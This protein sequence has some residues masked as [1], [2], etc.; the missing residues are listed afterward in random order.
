M[1]VLA[2]VA[3]TAIVTIEACPKPDSS[4]VVDCSFQDLITIPQLPA[5][6]IEV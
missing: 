5:T 4:G 2:V 6:A 1:F 3:V